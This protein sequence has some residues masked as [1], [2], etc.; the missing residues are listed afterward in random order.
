MPFRAREFTQKTRCYE[1]VEEKM[2]NI[3]E[4]KDLI[5]DNTK[6]LA[7]VV[8]QEE[9][10]ETTKLQSP[11][12]RQSQIVHQLEDH[13]KKLEQKMHDGLR[14]AIFALKECENPAMSMNEVVEHLSKCFSFESQEA[15]SALGQGLL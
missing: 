3:K 12:A 10:P 1:L 7:E 5:N 6:K 4:L 8:V 15:F 14:T 2:L 9:P 13:T 11:E